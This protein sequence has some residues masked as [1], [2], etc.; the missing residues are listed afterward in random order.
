[1]QHLE[2]I[3]ISYSKRS[4]PGT[5]MSLLWLSWAQWLHTVPWVWY[6]SYVVQIQMQVKGWLIWVTGLMLMPVC[7]WML[8][9]VFSRTPLGVTEHT[10][11]TFSSL[12]T[13]S[14]WHKNDLSLFSHCSH[15]V[16][17]ILYSHFLHW[18]GFQCTSSLKHRAPGDPQLVHLLH[19]LILSNHQLVVMGV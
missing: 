6:Q 3:S 14:I 13:D 17:H 12:K 1:M 4:S 5:K 11:I 7:A 9:K 8:A 10:E 16:S 2:K 19:R 18:K 15:I